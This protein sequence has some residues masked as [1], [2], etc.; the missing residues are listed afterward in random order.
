MDSR[1]MILHRL[2]AQSQDVD[3]TGAWSSRRR[4]KD[5]PE[6][7]ASALQAVKGE[8]HRVDSLESVWKKLG[9]LFDEI[10]A[11][12]VVANRE[13][14]LAKID[15]PEQFP[16]QEWFIVN[17]TE[18]DLRGFCAS[19]DIGVT[20]VVAGLAETGTLV[21]ESGMGRSRLVSLLPPVHV[22]LLPVSRLL[23][24]IFTWQAARQGSLPANLIFISGPSKTADIEQTLA[25]GVHGPKRLIVILYDD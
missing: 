15:L 20:S 14:P 11:L 5:L 7:F 18:G 3:L 10:G 1:E 19:G 9:Q 22:A 12:H 8:V 24:D 4:Y 23:P 2:K 17:Y 21:L 25:V 16:Q 13:A 6:Q